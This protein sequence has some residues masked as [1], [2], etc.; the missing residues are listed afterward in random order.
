MPASSSTAGAP[1]STRDS[2]GNVHARDA[3][4]SQ[5]RSPAAGRRSRR[6]CASPS[7]FVVSAPIL[8]LVHITFLNQPEDR[9]IF[10]GIFW[11]VVV[12]LILLLATRSEKMRRD[13]PDRR[14]AGS[15]AR[16]A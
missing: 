11:G 1:V 4:A 8:W 13:G 14:R 12:G 5:D 15:R 6:P 10:Y 3:E 16:R 7:A 2:V 9:G